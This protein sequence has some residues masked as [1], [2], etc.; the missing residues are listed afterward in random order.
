MADA[1][2]YFLG[3]LCQ[4][5]KAGRCTYYFVHTDELARAREIIMCIIMP[6]SM[7][8]KSNTVFADEKLEK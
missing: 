5:N 3:K 7:Q 6:K 2:F 4:V 1:D 8:A